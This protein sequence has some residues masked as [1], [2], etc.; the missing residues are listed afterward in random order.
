VLY[1]SRRV[2]VR[3]FDGRSAAWKAYMII[4]LGT[5]DWTEADQLVQF[6]TPCLRMYL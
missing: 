6:T 1:V 3:A 2:A 5:V 4:D